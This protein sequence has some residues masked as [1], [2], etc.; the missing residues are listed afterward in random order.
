MDINEK[1]K[2]QDYYKILFPEIPTSNLNATLGI[3][4]K[5]SSIP[6]KKYALKI[7]EVGA[8]DTKPNPPTSG[9]PADPA[10]S[11]PVDAP[12]GGGT[13]ASPEEFTPPESKEETVDKEAL[14]VLMDIK[15]IKHTLQNLKNELRINDTKE[16]I[17]FE[18]AQ[19]IKSVRKEIDDLKARKVPVRK[20]YDTE[21]A[22][23]EQL[24][25]QVVNILDDI[26][27]PL[28]NTIPDYNLLATQIS[29][30][31]DDGTIKNAIVSITASLVNNDYKYEFKIDVPVLNGLIQSPQY[32]TRARKII[33]MTEEAL[34]LELNSESFIK[35]SPDFR[36]KDNMFSNVGENMLRQHDK[37][38]MYPTNTPEQHSELSGDKSWITNRQRGLTDERQ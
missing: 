20:E 30:T 2:Q 35:V 10:A 36:Q 1:S 16:E 22:Y 32:M 6:M 3:G 29:S 38:K 9:K 34:Y 28:V 19:M 13:L 7:P 17:Q 25:P 5:Y 27:V 33:P 26:L 11:T 4:E 14:S 24:Y 21:G 12:A 15:D 18:V 23:K 8:K 37:Q 31:Y